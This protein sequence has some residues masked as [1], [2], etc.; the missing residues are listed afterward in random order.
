MQNKIDFLSSI[1]FGLAHQCRMH[2]FEQRQ[3]SISLIFNYFWRHQRCRYFCSPQKTI[4]SIVVGF[5]DNF[6]NFRSNQHPRAARGYLIFI[7]LAT[8]EVDLVATLSIL[9]FTK[10]HYFRLLFSFTTTLTTSAR[11]N[12]LERRG[13]CLY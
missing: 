13:S 12:I 6:N 8:K 4:V 1:S 2:S 9:S 5:D 10:I 11:I 7:S 3:K